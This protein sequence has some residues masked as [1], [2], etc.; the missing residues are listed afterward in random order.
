MHP[1]I[2]KI[3]LP[4]I[5][6]TAGL[7]FGGY[8]EQGADMALEK[9]DK[10][11]VSY[12]FR[13]ENIVVT[14][15]SKLEKSAIVKSLGIKE[16]SIFSFDMQAAR[17]RLEN[18]GWVKKAQ[19]SRLFPSTINIHI[20]EHKIFALW[21][22]RQ[23]Y[24]LINDEGRILT[25]VGEKSAGVPLVIGHSAAE[26]A[27]DLYTKIANYPQIATSIKSA[28]M[29]GNRRWDLRF[30]NGLTCMLPDGEFSGGLA[31]LAMIIDRGDFD[32][33]SI[34]DLRVPGRITVR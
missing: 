19:I 10:L 24:Y 17:E 31:K 27:R 9:A 21:Q 16:G 1:A 20:T 5:I 34:I 28:T 8:I 29:V 33:F 32:S 18:I 3:L 12:G 7:W 14:G 11:A 15:N 22:N 4:L 2:V 13:A 6:I 30:V 23:K 26:H 25:S